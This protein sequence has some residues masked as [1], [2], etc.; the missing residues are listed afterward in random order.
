[1]QSREAREVAVYAWFRSSSRGRSRVVARGG[2]GGRHG[3]VQAVP[4]A[5]F[6]SITKERLVATVGRYGM[7]SS[8]GRA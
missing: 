8:M 6:L 4:G 2:P 1:M 3:A 7:R 5:F